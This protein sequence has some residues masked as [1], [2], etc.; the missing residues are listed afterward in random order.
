MLF[1]VVNVFDV[2]CL[3]D[4]VYLF[5]YLMF[6]SLAQV[7]S[8]SVLPRILLLTSYMCIANSAVGCVLFPQIECIEDEDGDGG[9]Q[10]YRAPPTASHMLRGTDDAEL[11]LHGNSVGS[12]RLYTYN[13]VPNFLKGNPFITHGYRLYLPTGLCFKR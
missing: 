6:L 8:S 12:F 5:V 2:C 3:F 7:E 10:G 9:I 11:G 13:E 4:V 1:D